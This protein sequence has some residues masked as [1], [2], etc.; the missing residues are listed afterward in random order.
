MHP[1]ETVSENFLY[2]V[3]PVFSVY[4]TN[5][6]LPWWFTIDFLCFN[7]GQTLMSHSK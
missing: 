5:D 3:L 6:A 1:I 4:S 7:L 2:L